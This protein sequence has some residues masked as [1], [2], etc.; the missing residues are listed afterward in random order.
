MIRKLG[1]QRIIYSKKI[2][3]QDERTRDDKQIYKEDETHEYEETHGDE[4][5]EIERIE[6]EIKEIERIEREIKEIE[7]TE[8]KSQLLFICA[9][10]DETY[11]HWQVKLYLHN[12]TKYV[13]KEQCYAI[14]GYKD[15]PSEE[16]IKLKEEYPHI[17]WYKDERE[18]K[19]TYISSI[20][21]FLLKKFFKDKPYVGKLFFYHDSDILFRKF[22]DFNKMIHDD[23]NYLSD[24][25]GYIGS[26][27]I[28]IRCKKCKRGNDYLPENDLLNKMAECIGL[29]VEVIEKNQDNSGGAQYLLKDI[30][31]TFWEKCETDCIKLYKLMD[32]Y[33]KKHTGGDC[34]I[35]KWCSDMWCLLWNLWKI[36]RKTIVDPE[37]SFSWAPGS[38]EK[39]NRHNIFHLAGINDSNCEGK[40]YKGKFVHRCPIKLL[41]NN[42]KYFDYVSK[43]NATYKYIENMKD[44]I[45]SNT[46]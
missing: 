16:I 39:Y 7:E 22:P 9:Q 42:S 20:R 25:I 34:R 23:Q 8:Q 41:R 5:N 38:I 32:D 43:D 4:I 1:K 36:D 46:I 6:R 33:M 30:D 29:P 3:K 28:K 13:D 27:Y 18:D 11:F 44:Y 31:W 10:P 17:Y 35:Q 37:L 45:K 24:T 15:N 14:F 40:F 21:P 26:R 2:N 19:R 12:F